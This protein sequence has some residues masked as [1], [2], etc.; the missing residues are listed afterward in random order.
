MSYF[1]GV[2]A[3]G[4]FA[5]NPIPLDT[6]NGRS[7]LFKGGGWYLLGVQSLSALCLAC[8]GISITFGLLWIINKIV[9][10]RMD[11]NEELL[12]ADLMEHRIRHAQV[13]IGHKTL[14][15]VISALQI[16]SRLDRNRRSTGS[17]VFFNCKFGDEPDEVWS[18]CVVN[19]AVIKNSNAVLRFKIEIHENVIFLA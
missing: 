19:T 18:L 7:G 12:G 11:P 16:T 14:K 13:C 5:D 15:G 17:D 4:L 2:L 1:L 9:P 10:I 6:T 8:W 3:V